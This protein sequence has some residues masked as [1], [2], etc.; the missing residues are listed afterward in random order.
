MKYCTFFISLFLSFSCF[1]AKYINDGGTNHFIYA[2]GTADGANTGNLWYQPAH[3]IRPPVGTYH[4]N[5]PL[6]NQQISALKASGQTSYVITIFNSNIG[7]CEFNACNDGVAD[8]VWGHVIDNTGYQMRAQHRQNLQE[9]VGKALDVGFRKIIIRF[10]ANSDP[11]NWTGGWDENKYQQVWNFIIDARNAARGEVLSRGLSNMFDAPHSILVFDLGLEWGGLNA[12]NQFHPFMKRLWQD[13]HF[14]YGPNDTVGFSIAWAK[15]RFTALQSLLNST[16]LPLPKMWAFDVYQ[17]IQTGLG[18]IYTEMG[19]LKN[20]PV[21]IAETYFNDAANAASINS[22]IQNND[23]LNVVSLNQWPAQQS[24]PNQ[25]F[26]HFAI[27]SLVS[28]TSFNGYLP[29]LAKRKIHLTSSNANFLGV[30]DINCAGG[31]ASLCTVELVWS[32]PPTNRRYGIYVRSGSSHTLV[33]C[34][35]S[36]GRDVMPWIQNGTRYLFDI[37]EIPSTTCPAQP[38]STSILRATAEASLF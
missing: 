4:L 2:Y 21:I 37:Y 1:A 13:Y 38:S 7:D 9:I 29:L 34:N 24:A 16:S 25:H 8:G 23:L 35:A 20:Q 11:Q 27:N 6:V 26:T 31:T 19:S 5:K 22:A 18:E 33:S 14:T 28:L 10:A 32:K 12:Q 30:K 17:N 15:G 3:N 36:A